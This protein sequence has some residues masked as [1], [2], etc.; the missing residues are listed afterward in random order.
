MKWIRTKMDV[1]VAVVVISAFIYVPFF[2]ILSLVQNN[3]ALSILNKLD[4][5]ISFM[6]IASC[7]ILLLWM[8]LKDGS[9]SPLWEWLPPFVFF[10]IRAEWGRWVF[11]SFLVLGTLI[12]IVRSFLGK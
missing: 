4:F 5:F 12:G 3:S 1:L 10:R 2:Q 6:G 7:V 9:K 11:I 8:G